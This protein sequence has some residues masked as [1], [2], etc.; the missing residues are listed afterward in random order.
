MKRKAKGRPTGARACL[1]S[2]V[3]TARCDTCGVRPDIL[4]N[5]I[6]ERG[7]FCGLHCVACHPTLKAKPSAAEASLFEAKP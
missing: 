7:F 2:R 6:F 5:P 3:L 4:H 1:R